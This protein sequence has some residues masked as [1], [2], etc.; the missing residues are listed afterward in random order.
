MRIAIEMDGPVADPQSRY[1]SAYTQAAEEL[2]LARLD[3]AE[4][5]RR[6]RIA[7]PLGRW[8]PGATPAKIEAFRARFEELLDT[9]ERIAAQSPAA[10]VVEALIRL[11][12]HAELAL[13]SLS[14][15]RTARQAWLDAHDFSVHFLRMVALPRDGSARIR[16]LKDLVEA[17]KP[18][19]ICGASIP[20]IQAARSAQMLVVGI[21]NGAMTPR[22]LTQIGAMAVFSDLEELADDLDEG[23][24]RLRA[25]GL[26]P[27]APPPIINP[28]VSKAQ[29]PQPRLRRR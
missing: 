26:T 28:I 22:R 8:L 21:G 4:F 20:V 2:R 1:W 14:T 27:P 7:D 18:T 13:I 19:L 17:Q 11:K 16:H 25:I 29:R 3:P 15:N 6:V 12:R 9:D 24:P 23:A 5:W 10:G